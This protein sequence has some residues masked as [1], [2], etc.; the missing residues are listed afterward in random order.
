MVKAG[1]GYGENLKKT[2]EEI[3]HACAEAILGIRAAIGDIDKSLENRITQI[4]LILME[5]LKK[6]QEIS[7]CF[8]P[9]AFKT[10]LIDPT[11]DRLDKL[12]DKLYQ[13]L[14]QIIDKLAVLFHVTITD[15]KTQL[16]TGLTTFVNPKSGIRKRRFVPVRV[17]NLTDM[18]L[19]RYM[20][21]LELEKINKIIS[22]NGSVE[23]IIDSYLQLKINAS[24]M[25]FRARSLGI[26]EL[27][28]ICLR[29]WVKYGMAI[30]SLKV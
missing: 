27:Q 6:A 4:A 8:T 3:N 24:R 2:F 11:F 19:Y 18:E 9:G 13:D 23:S 14:D 22:D 1:I 25:N 10:K 15:V 12:E 20:T 17:I 21:W 29:D 7:N 16:L 28:N 30:E 26:T 5:T